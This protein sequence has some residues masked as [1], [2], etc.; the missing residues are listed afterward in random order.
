MKLYLALHES[1]HPD[2]TRILAEVDGK[3]I[4]LNLAY[5]AL[6]SETANHASAYELA[7]YYFPPTLAAFLQRGEPA[8]EALDEVATF[9]R[10]S[11]VGELRGPAREK[12]AYDAKEVRLLPPLQ[13]PEKSFVIGFSDR[14]RVIDPLPKADIPTGFYKLPQTFVANRAP[15]VWPKFSN[16]VD[17][18]GCLAIVIGKA[19]KRIAPE[20]AWEHVAG[21]MLMI[22][23]TA[24]DVNKREGLTNNNLL[25]KNFPSSTCLGP[26]VLIGNSRKDFE[27]LEVELSI[28]R[29]VKQRF[30]LRDCVFTVEQIIA[31]WSILGIKP[32]DWLAIGASMALTGDRLQNPVPFKIGSTIRCFSPAI[33][34]LSHQVVPSGGLRR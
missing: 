18:D 7:D 26:A 30:A 1:S 14:A 4:D 12:I 19:G 9:A 2:Q 32:G 15:I 28:N 29:V 20:K 6:L 17:A 33:G 11:G 23:I 24:R 31:R 22:D 13:N 16:E 25:G 8:R 21:A 10:R 3:L 34:E 27:A 5:A